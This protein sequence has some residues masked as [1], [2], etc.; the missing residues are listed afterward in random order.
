MGNVLEVQNLKKTFLEYKF[1]NWKLSKISTEAVR[2]ISFFLKKGEILGLLGPNGA[3]KTTTIQMLLGTLTPTSGKISYFGKEF[4]GH[5]PEILKRTNFSSAYIELPW[6]MTV[7][8]NLD[9]YG[10]IYEVPDRNKRIL[11]LL[12]R[13]GLLELK[14]RKMRQ[15]SSGQTTRVILA[16]AFL[17][18]PEAILMDEP[19]ASLDPEIAKQVRQ[20]LLEQQKEFGV[21]M[22][23]TSHNMKEVEEVCD[24]IIFINQGKII[25]EDTPLE[26][27]KRFKETKIRFRVGTGKEDLESYLQEK[28]Y[29]SKW[30][31]GKVI[32][33][34]EED[35]IPIVLYRISQ[36][37]VRYQDLEVIR[38]D[39]EDFFLKVAK[40]EKNE[41]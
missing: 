8:E 30:Y 26:L 7:W 31:K 10:R 17:N 40:G 35:K 22:L 25:A 15:L 33:N 4:K 16:K 41:S 37:G 14:D 32:I 1:R 38:P 21:S 6:R 20:F 9:V 36:L 5:D 19:T 27:I 3:G 39:L 34:L 24:R 18:Y 12:S 29:A 23:F 28:G 13:F 11:K 2:G